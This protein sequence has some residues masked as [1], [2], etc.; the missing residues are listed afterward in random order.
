MKTIKAEIEIIVRSKINGN[1]YQLDEYI[2]N[3]YNHLKPKQ[4]FTGF[5][6]TTDGELSKRTVEL[7]PDNLEVVSSHAFENYFKRF[8]P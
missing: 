3:H 2:E 6:I 7:A 8:Y 4:M 5:I 1:M